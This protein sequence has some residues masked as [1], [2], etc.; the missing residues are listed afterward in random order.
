MQPGTPA[1]SDRVVLYPDP[2]LRQSAAPVTAFD[3]GLQ[4]MAGLLGT[5][6]RTIPAIGLAGPHLGIM[7]RIVA[8]DT[9]RAGGGVGLYV[10]PKVAWTSAETAEHEEG[11][12]SLPGLTAKVTR[13]AS[14]RV[15]FQDL[16]GAVREEE[17]TG[18]LAACLQHEIDQ[19]DGLFWLERL[20]RLKRER[21]LARF[22]KLNR[23]I[24]GAI[25]APGRTRTERT[26]P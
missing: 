8:L 26:S 3:D 7:H 20:S 9:E 18:F 14:L 22:A 24:P 4:L 5:A 15:T 13:A 21:L 11:S 1:V 12:V 16:G 10:N 25:A 17:A 19:L 23:A 6:L 2:R